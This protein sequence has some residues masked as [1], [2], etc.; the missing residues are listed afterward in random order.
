MTGYEIASA[1]FFTGL[2]LL[3]I[4]LVCGLVVFVEWLRNRNQPVRV[5]PHDQLDWRDGTENFIGGTGWPRTAAAL[6]RNEK[7]AATV[8]RPAPMTTHGGTH[9]PCSK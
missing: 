9:D 4:A 8:G 6:A 5:T 3:M 2:I 7:E 1:M